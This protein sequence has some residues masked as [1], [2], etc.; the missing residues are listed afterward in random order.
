MYGNLQNSL[1]E[2]FGE[3]DEPKIA[4]SSILGIAFSIV[5]K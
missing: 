3:P 2:F 4:I 1:P 5:E